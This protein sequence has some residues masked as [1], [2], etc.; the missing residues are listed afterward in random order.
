MYALY[1]T[2]VR[3]F[4]LYPSAS[5]HHPSTARRDTLR[6]VLAAGCTLAFVMHVSYLTLLPRFDY[7]YNI[8]FNLV[9]G[10]THNLLWLLYSLPTSASPFH[11]FPERPKTYRPSFV[12]KAA[13]FVLLTTAATALELF[14]F[15][16]WFRTVDAHALWHLSTAPIAGF[17]YEFLLQDAGDEGWRSKLE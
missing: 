11:R 9:V 6:R 12:Y 14:D 17:W 1:Y 8:I 5:V 7:T 10:T 2:T 15:P 13:V 4:H 3:L 16:P